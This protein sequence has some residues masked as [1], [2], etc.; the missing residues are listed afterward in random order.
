[1]A[2]ICIAPGG[3]HPS[4]IEIFPSNNLL[5]ELDGVRLVTVLESKLHYV[6]G[7]VLAKTVNVNFIE[8]DNR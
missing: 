8:Q 1:M 7:L 2:R 6:T 5:M 3:T 4:I